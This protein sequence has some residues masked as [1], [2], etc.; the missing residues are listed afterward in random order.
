MIL[1]N[2]GRIKSIEWLLYKALE[3]REPKL[4]K[5]G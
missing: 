3:K 1:K 4:Y 2:S 5:E